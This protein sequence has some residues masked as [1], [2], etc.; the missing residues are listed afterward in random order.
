MRR[1][2]VRVGR[3]DEEVFCN[4]SF[5]VFRSGSAPLPVT[6]PLGDTVHGPTVPVETA[7]LRAVQESESV[8]TETLFPVRPL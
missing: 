1:G 7:F 5:L 2:R 4:V 8:G 3:D 6:M